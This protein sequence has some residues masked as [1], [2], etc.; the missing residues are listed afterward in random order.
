V[1][2]CLTY[3]SAHSAC[4][5]DCAREHRYPT[6]RHPPSPY[7]FPH[8]GGFPSEESTLIITDN[9][10]RSAPLY[11]RPQRVLFRHSHGGMGAGSTHNPFLAS[12]ASFSSPSRTVSPSAYFRYHQHQPFLT[13]V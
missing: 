12:R 10:A 8:A 11:W 6:S 1:N 3:R 2:S 13:S 5:R 4:A 7:E 9:S